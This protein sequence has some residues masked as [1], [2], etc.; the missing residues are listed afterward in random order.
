[1]EALMNIE[2]YCGNKQLEINEDLYQMCEGPVLIREIQTWNN[3]FV[4]DDGTFWRDKLLTEEI[5]ADFKKHLS[6][7][8]RERSNKT[9]PEIY[10]PDYDEYNNVC[11]GC[12]KTKIHIV[13]KRFLTNPVPYGPG[14]FDRIDHIIPS[15]KTWNAVENLRYTNAHLNSL[16]RRLVGDIYYDAD[17]RM[18]GAEFQTHCMGYKFYHAGFATSF[19]DIW[20]LYDKKRIEAYNEWEKF[21]ISR[22]IKEHGLQ[23]N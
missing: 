21:Y 6:V 20:R 5:K 11:F 22:F 15:L 2:K 7:K 16:N 18:W 1:M 23:E 9:T 19:L 10:W 17:I 8:Q 12:R 3:Y 13:M 14:K 4:C